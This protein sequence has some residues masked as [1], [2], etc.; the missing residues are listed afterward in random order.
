[1]HL[2]GLNFSRAWNLYHLVLQL[3]ASFNSDKCATSRNSCLVRSIIAVPFSLSR[4]R[5]FALAD[6][7]VRESKD[8]VVDGTYAATHWLATFMVHA[9]IE[10]EAA[11]EALQ[12]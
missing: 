10:R 8:E 6:E 4:R 12:V 9:L 5:F 3:P 2:E 1:M 7:H 11:A